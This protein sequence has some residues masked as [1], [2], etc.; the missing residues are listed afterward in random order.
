V[1][2]FPA[3]RRAEIVGIISDTDILAAVAGRR[4]LGHRRGPT[5][6]IAADIMRPAAEGRRVTEARVLAPELSV[7]QCAALLSE[8]RTREL[9]VVQDGRIIGVVADTDIVHVLEQRGGLT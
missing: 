7:W 6:R 5:A 4:W 1:R 2:R 8:A 9:P 3:T